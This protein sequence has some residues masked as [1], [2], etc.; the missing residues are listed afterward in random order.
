MIV[1]GLSAVTMNASMRATSSLRAHGA[2]PSSVLISPSRIASITKPE[3]IARASGVSV[4]SSP[5]V[6]AESNGRKPRNKCTASARLRRRFLG[7]MLGSVVVPLVATAQSRGLYGSS[8]CKSAKATDESSFAFSSNVHAAARSPSASASLFS[9]L[10]A[11]SIAAADH[12]YASLS[13]AFERRVNSD[14]SPLPLKPNATSKPTPTAI[15]TSAQTG[16]QWPS[17]DSGG[18]LA[19]A[20]HIS[21]TTPATITPPKKTAMF[22]QSDRAR[23][24]SPS[25]A[26]ITS[27]L[28]RNAKSKGA[29][30]AGV[31]FGALIFAILIA[32]SPLIK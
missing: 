14:W 5:S 30:F 31:I 13:F 1:S 21:S 10:S 8:P 16:P 24:K 19:N 18:N 9:A 32:A 2:L 6:P 15:R 26:Y 4:T 3:T 25:L 29:F 28:R 22:S 23:S 11:R 7:I 17:S 12:R 27:F 20:S